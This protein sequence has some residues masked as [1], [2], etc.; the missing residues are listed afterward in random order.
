[1][2]AAVN[3]HFPEDRTYDLARLAA[4]K[5]LRAVSYKPIEKQKNALTSYLHRQGFSWDIIK[6]I[7][8]DN[9]DK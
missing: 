5:K 7:I 3:E 8:A 4:E 1:M 2:K 6:Q 9:F